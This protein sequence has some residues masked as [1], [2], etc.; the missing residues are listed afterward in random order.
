MISYSYIYRV[1]EKHDVKDIIDFI[2]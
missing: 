1:Y 2:I